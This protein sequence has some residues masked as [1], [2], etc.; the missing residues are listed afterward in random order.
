MKTNVWCLQNINLFNEFN[1][2]DMLILEK[3][4]SMSPVKKNEPIFLPGDP[5]REVYLLKTGRVKISRITE[6]G[7]ELTMALLK[8]GNIFGEL[9]A[10][11]GTPRD[12]L[13]E[14]LD[15][16]VLCLIPRDPF[17]VMLKSK[18][19]LSFRL[20]KII[21]FRLRRIESRIEE[22]VYKDV[23]TRVAHVLIE[24]ARDFG[25]QDDKGTRIGIRL[26][27]QE[28]ANLIGSTRETVTAT[29]GDLRR[30]GFLEFDNRSILITNL[31]RLSSLPK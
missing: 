16:T 18:P 20:T 25:T 28:I 2:E 24:M 13:A 11:D 15:D 29:L 17:L 22:L 1:R 8:P 12:T 27:H 19:D 4:A 23:P 5:S 9:E 3:V 14:A 26:T 31:D 6:N 7:K 30:Q 10:L 21:G